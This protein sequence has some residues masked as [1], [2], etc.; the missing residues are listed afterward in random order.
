[1]EDPI[2]TTSNKVI[3]EANH[4]AAV[5]GTLSVLPTT[6]SAAKV[7]LKRSTGMTIDLISIGLVALL[8]VIYHSVM[9]GLAAQD[10]LSAVLSDNR[11]FIY[12]CLAIS[13]L[14][15]IYLRLVFRKIFRFPTPGEMFAGVSTV[16]LLPGL[17][18][19]LQEAVYSVAQYFTL[20]FASIFGVMLIVILACSGLLGKDGSPQELLALTIV[21]VVATLASAVA[22]WP[23]SK[24]DYQSFVDD[25]SKVRVNRMR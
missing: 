22:Y 9:H 16:T 20:A 18:G 21:P 14:P 12:L 15:M 5:G 23:R 11:I 25:F 4:I 19:F 17:A 8:P 3:D 24:E 13:P 1:M 10:I 7:A 6:Q 2:D